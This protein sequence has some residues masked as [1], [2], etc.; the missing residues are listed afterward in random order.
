MCR[1]YF[2][3]EER[4]YF[5][6]FKIKLW[7]NSILIGYLRYL[8]LHYSSFETLPY[9]IAK[10]KHLRV[11]ILNKNGKIKWFPQS[12]SKLYN[13]KVLVLGGC[14]KLITT[15]QYVLSLAEFVNLNHLQVL[16]FHCCK[17]MKFL[18]SGEEQLNSIEILSLHS[19]WSVETIP[20]YI[21]PKLESL[22]IIYCKIAHAN[23]SSCKIWSS[24]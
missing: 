24:S 12:I 14:T 7:S 22:I 23:C 3:T 9:S 20:L 1:G 8:D 21:F 11:L 2:R 19:C 17:N 18:Y 6:C 5:T 10:L 13:L 15:K 4:W 16:G